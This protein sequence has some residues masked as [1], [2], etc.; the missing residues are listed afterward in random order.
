MRRVKEKTERALNTRLFLKGERCSSPKCA[1]VRKPYKPGVHGQ[2][3]RFR[4]ISEY[5]TQLQEK[6]K[7]QITYGLKGN[8][9]QNLFNK[10]EKTK[11]LTR[12]EE[13]L[14][15]TVFQGGLALSP[16]IARQLVSHGHIEV[17]GRKTTIPSH[18]LTK[19]DII[20]VRESS[21]KLKSFEDLETL[22]KRAT[23]PSW[24]KVG[25]DMFTREYTNTPEIKTENLPFDIDLV[26]EYYSR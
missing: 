10:Y 9:L 24:I 1:L 5:G 22:T 2:K 25:K 8:T 6:Q 3:R 7:L 14:D 20:K 18:R 21:R 13:R 23:L 17:N 26:G 4:K 19:G 16:R 15:R 12:L 11:V